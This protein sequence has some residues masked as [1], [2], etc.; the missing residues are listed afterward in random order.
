[1][2]DPLLLLSFGMT[3]SRTFASDN[4]LSA[5]SSQSSSFID[6][7]TD[8]LSVATTYKGFA[9]GTIQIDRK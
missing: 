3:G 5:H 6:S 4:A 9:S 7:E 1:M 8:T 2:D